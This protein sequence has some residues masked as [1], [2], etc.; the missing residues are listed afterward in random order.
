MTP[1]QN[2]TIWGYFARPMQY[3]RSFSRKDVLRVSAILGVFLV[4]TL[5]PVLLVSSAASVYNVSL[6][7]TPTHPSYPPH[8]SPS[9][10]LTAQNNGA[11]TFDAKTC[12]ITV[13]GPNNYHHTLAC[14]TDFKPFSLASG[15]SFTHF[16]QSFVIIPA[17][18]PKGTYHFICYL[19][20]T[21]NGAPF[22]TMSTT[23]DIAVS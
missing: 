22:R 11:S 13:S 21:V 16:Y 6:N 17:K 3:A 19:D 4:F 2:F 18:T 14:P 5:S 20:G 10:T 8:T 15:H 7:V 12:T 1:A 23:F 9:A